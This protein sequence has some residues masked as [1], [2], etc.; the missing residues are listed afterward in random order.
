M[1]KYKFKIFLIKNGQSNSKL[2]SDGF[3]EELKKDSFKAARNELIRI[4]ETD[5]NGNNDAEINESIERITNGYNQYFYDNCHYSTFVFSK[6]FK[7]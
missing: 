3:W 7:N 5:R 2:I 1:K 6:N 4:A